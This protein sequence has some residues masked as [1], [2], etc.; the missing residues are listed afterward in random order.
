MKKHFFLMMIAVA[1]IAFAGCKKDGGEPE[2]QPSLSVA[3]ESISAEAAAGS[4]TIAV[5]TNVAWTAAINSGATWCTVL[6]AAGT[7]NGTVTVNVAENTAV[8]EQRAA[9]ITVAASTLTKTVDVT[10]QGVSY[11]ASPQTWTF[12]SQTWS[13]RIVAAPANCTQTNSLTTS[14]YTTAEYKISDGRYYYSWTCAVNAATTLCPSPWRVPTQSDFSALVS[15]LGG[16]SAYQTLIDAWGLG[17]YAFGSIMND[18]STGA[19]YW[20]STE[21]DTNAYYLTYLSSYVY[22]QNYAGKYNGFQVRC[23]K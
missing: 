5:T 22:P 2:V 6:P 4:Y 14:N 16:S 1:A 18:V 10:Q 13:D 8:G 7:E 12:G 21:D 15:A 23:V 19:Y 3:P 17:G 9:T 11:A 20:S